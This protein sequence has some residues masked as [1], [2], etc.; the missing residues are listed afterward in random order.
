MLDLEVIQDQGKSIVD[1]LNNQFSRP[2]I[3]ACEAT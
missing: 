3:A 2:E 1:A